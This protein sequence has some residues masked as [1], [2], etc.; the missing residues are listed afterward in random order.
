MPHQKNKKKKTITVN[1]AMK[2]WV[3]EQ[4][5]S[6]RETERKLKTEVKYASWAAQQQLKDGKASSVFHYWVRDIIY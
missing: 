1:I 3:T 5:W 2:L 4:S 6:I